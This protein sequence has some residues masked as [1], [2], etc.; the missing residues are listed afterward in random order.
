MPLQDVQQ[1]EML[2]Q[3]LNVLP[4]NVKAI[5]KLQ[6]AEQA[7]NVAMLKKSQ[8]NVLVGNAG[9]NTL[10]TQACYSTYVL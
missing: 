7:V 10:L 8:Q 4:V 9:S 5:K 6:N 1:V 2:R 3:K